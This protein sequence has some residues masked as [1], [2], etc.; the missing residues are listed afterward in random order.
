MDHVAFIRT[1]HVTRLLTGEKDFE[2]RL[3]KRPGPA[4]RAS[5]GDRV[6]LKRSGG[7]IEGVAAVVEIAAL[8]DLRPCDVLALADTLLPS[9]APDWSYWRQK[10]AARYALILWLSPVQRCVVPAA[11]TPR[12]VQSAWVANWRHGDSA[13]L[14]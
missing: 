9:S 2:S 14:I 13:R 3:A 11:L 10:Q 4:W 1:P 12:G 8:D 5:V 7:E 6:F